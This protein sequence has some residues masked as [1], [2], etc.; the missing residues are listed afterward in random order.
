[1]ER[2]EHTGRKA[3]R[4]AALGTAG[5]FAGAIA[6][7]GLRDPHVPG[8]GFPACPF[9]L[10]TGWNCP[11]CGGLRMTHDLLH[12][13]ITAAVVDNVFLLVGLPSLML[14]LI[15]RWRGGRPLMPKSAMAVVVV[16]VLTWTVV[17]NLPGFPLVPMFSAG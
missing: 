6:Y 15:L 17:R 4:Y 1:M 13:D 12:G 14:W 2:S 3:P 9:R 5:I 16:A 7:V 8:F 11:G 10:L